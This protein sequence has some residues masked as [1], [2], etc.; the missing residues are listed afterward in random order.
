VSEPI[1]L[2]DAMSTTR[3][4]RRFRPDSIPDDV[5]SS[6][7]EAA[8]WAPSGSNSQNWR[9]LVVRDPER[10]RRVGEIYRRGFDEFYPPGRLATETD[11]SRQRMMA[12]GVHLAAHIGEEP[13]VLLL[14]CRDDPTRAASVSPSGIR[15]W[16]RGSSVYPAVQNVLLAARA[17]G[18]GGCLTTVHLL[19]EEEIKAALDIPDGIDTYALVP[20]G[21]PRD[22][23]GPLRRR[24]VE[25]IAFADAWGAPFGS[26]SSAADRQ[27]GREGQRAQ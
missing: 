17:Y 4:I 11:P 1:G 7:L 21:Y 27:V 20:L 10:R 14:F 19:H 24:P 2:L 18:L 16:T 26:G 23:F 12:G 6:V 3:S 8:T 13:P 25:E 15:P 22:R 5:L 9:L